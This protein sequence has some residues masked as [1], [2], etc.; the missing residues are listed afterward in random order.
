MKDFG[1]GLR[2]PAETSWILRKDREGDG[3]MDEAGETNTRLQSPGTVV[4]RPQGPRGPGLLEHGEPT[5]RVA[6]QRSALGHSSPKTRSCSRMAAALSVT[7]AVRP[8]PEAHG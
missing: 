8:G 4:G 7:A 1:Q 2:E 3:G 5:L 6:E